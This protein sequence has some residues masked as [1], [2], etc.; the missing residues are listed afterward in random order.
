MAARLDSVA[1][2]ICEKSGWSVSNLQLQKLMYLAQMIHMGRHGGRRL[3]DGDFQAWDYGP[4]EPTLYHK[5]KRFGSDSVENVFSDAR[6][7][8][9]EDYRRKVMDDVC[10]RFLK[11]SAGDLVD[12]THW[13]G[14]AWA[15]NYVPKA[16][17]RAIPDDE[18]WQEYKDRNRKR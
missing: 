18:I 4:V 16:R 10:D 12:I 11:Y 17:N 15:K 6:T 9:N 5:T 8:R 13:D 7:F 1:Q 3:F 14:G 2:Y